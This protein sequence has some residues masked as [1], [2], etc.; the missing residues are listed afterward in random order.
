MKKFIDRWWIA[1]CLFLVSSTGSYHSFAQNDT[2]WHWMNGDYITN[3]RTIY[4]L[5]TVF[6]WL[7]MPGARS[8]SAAWKDQEGNFW[9]MGGF[10]FDGNGRQGNM[11]DLWQLQYNSWIWKKGSDTTGNPG[12]Y[13]SLG[14]TSVG[15]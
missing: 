10:G 8:G 15:S 11:N 13:G 5:I 1:F 7:P 12:D 14:I 2:S 9:L 3:A 6:P 4:H